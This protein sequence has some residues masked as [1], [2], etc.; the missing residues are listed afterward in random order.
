MSNNIYFM[1]ACVSIR[2]KVAHIHKTD[3]D[4]EDRHRKMYLLIIQT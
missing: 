1:W 3:G 4:T 2:E